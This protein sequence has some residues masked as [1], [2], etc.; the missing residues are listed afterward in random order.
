MLQSGYY[1]LYLQMW[2]DNVTFVNIAELPKAGTAKMTDQPPWG[3]LVADIFSWLGAG[4]WSDTPPS[5]SDKNGLRS[6]W[7]L[8]AGWRIGCKNFEQSNIQGATPNNKREQYKHVGL[9]QARKIVPLGRFLRCLP[10]PTQNTT[11]QSC[12]SAKF[13]SGTTPAPNH[14]HRGNQSPPRGKQNNAHDTTLAVPALGN[15][16]GDTLKANTKS[17]SNI[18]GVFGATHRAKK[19]TPK[20]FARTDCMG[21]TAY[22]AE[23]HKCCFFS[24]Y[25]CIP[26]VLMS[27][28]IVSLLGFSSISLFMP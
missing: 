28:Y 15:N 19:R 21:K 6:N 26:Q 20:T 17:T 27:W 1:A 24:K 3:A 25:S 18:R 9:G 23:S 10:R 12:C 22:S 5:Q 4:V 14:T 13:L 16:Y 2:S 7:F 8:V 11:L